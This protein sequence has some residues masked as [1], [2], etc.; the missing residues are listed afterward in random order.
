MSVYMNEWVSEWVSKSKWMREKEWT[1]ECHPAC[2]PLSENDPSKGLLISLSFTSFLP[3]PL[4]LLVWRLDYS[5]SL[6]PLG[7]YMLHFL[8]ETREGGQHSQS[9]SIG[10]GHSKCSLTHILLVWGNPFQEQ[11]SFL[12][13][14]SVIFLSQHAAHNAYKSQDM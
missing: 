5:P 12:V 13:D 10:S 11:H 6:C 4:H 7:L 9:K 1:N 14:T 3:P 2:L 8:S